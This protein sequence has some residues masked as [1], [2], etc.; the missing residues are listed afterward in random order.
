VSYLLTVLEIWLAIQYYGNFCLVF[1]GLPG[2]DGKDGTP[3]IPGIKVRPGVDGIYAPVAVVG[4]VPGSY[5]D[6]W[7]C[8]DD[9]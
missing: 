4:V 8:G 6:Q 2:I 3:G 5:L 1:Q 7:S 9:E